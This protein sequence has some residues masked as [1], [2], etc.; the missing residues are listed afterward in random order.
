MV[1]PSDQFLVH[2]TQQISTEYLADTD[3][4]WG[5]WRAKQSESVEQLTQLTYKM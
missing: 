2:P 3:Q 1:P 5:E 4:P